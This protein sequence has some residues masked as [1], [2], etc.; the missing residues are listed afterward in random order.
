MAAQLAVYS[1]GR[2][3]R[4]V[5]VLPPIGLLTRRA[6]PPV[7]AV[8][9]TTWA[10]KVLVAATAT[11]GPALV[12]RVR[13]AARVMLLSRTLVIA[14]VRQPASAARR[15]ADTVSAVSPDWER[16]MTML[17]AMEDLPLRSMTTTSSAL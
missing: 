12:Y 6:R 10:R 4:V 3:P 8:S 1:P 14:R 9:E 13:S 5:P 16:A 17:S 11:S 7:P 15:T 2:L